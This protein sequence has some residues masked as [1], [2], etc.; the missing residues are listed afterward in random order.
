MKI[1]SKNMV[2]ISIVLL[3][4]YEVFNFIIIKDDLSNIY[5][6]RNFIFVGLPFFY[7]G[8]FINENKVENKVDKNIIIIIL[9]FILLTIEICNYTSELYFCSIILS[10]YL[11]LLCI[12][13]PNVENKA[14]EFI[15][16]KLSMYM[17]II[18]P[19][20]KYIIIYL[21]EYLNWNGIIWEYINPLIMLL[22]TL[23]ISYSLYIKKMKKIKVYGNN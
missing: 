22:T 18:H 9:L 3:L 21:F 14:L 5:L 4:L 19:A 10:I 1:K 7:I 12:K 8:K 11:F 17:Y 6:I 13:Y 2:I 23:I 16:E 15:G 20:I